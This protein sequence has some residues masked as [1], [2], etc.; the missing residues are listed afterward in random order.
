MAVLLLAGCGSAP[1]AG[2]E[3]DLL[4]AAEEASPPSAVAVRPPDPLPEFRV[5]VDVNRSYTNPTPP[6]SPETAGQEW[7]VAELEVGSAHRNVTFEFS[8]SHLSADVFVP[9]CRL[10]RGD[11]LQQ[12]DTFSDSGL[13]QAVSQGTCILTVSELAPGTYRAAYLVDGLQPLGTHQ[14]RLRVTG[15]SAPTTGFEP[16]SA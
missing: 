11:E 16:V 3:A 6:P 13:G 12:Q 5:L 2:T 4:L 1:E 15:W 10:Y 8:R 9:H 14:V 7:I